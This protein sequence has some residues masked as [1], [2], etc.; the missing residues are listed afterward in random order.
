MPAIRFT[1]CLCFT[2]LSASVTAALA[3]EINVTCK[4]DY[5]VIDTK[6]SKDLSPENIYLIHTNGRVVEIDAPFR[7]DEDNSLVEY[8][9]Q[10][11]TIRCN[12]TPFLT[13]VRINRK[14]GR[15]SRFTQ[16][17]DSNPLKYEDVSG[18]CYRHGE[19]F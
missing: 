14:T 17:V 5:V 7:C 13:V 19:I 16:I 15:Y 2:S 10:V 8:E 18:V 11:L 1:S 3:E 12:S 6:F 4:P 9:D